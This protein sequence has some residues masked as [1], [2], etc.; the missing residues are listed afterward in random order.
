MHRALDVFEQG[1]QALDAHYSGQC[2]WQS[3]EEVLVMIVGV[4]T[5]ILACGGPNQTKRGRAAA[6]ELL[7]CCC[8]AASREF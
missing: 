5:S 4:K 1:K 7:L 2:W 8:F 6:G 3:K